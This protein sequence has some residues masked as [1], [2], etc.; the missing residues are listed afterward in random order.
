MEKEVK[1][2]NLQAPIGQSLRDRIDAVAGDPDRQWTR[3]QAAR[4]LIER[5]LQT[6]EFCPQECDGPRVHARRSA[7]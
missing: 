4:W 2:Y 6:I 5:G 3:A 7:A 1:T